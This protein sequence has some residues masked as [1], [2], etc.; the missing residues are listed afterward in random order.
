MTSS[1]GR[2]PLWYSS[3]YWR[4]AISFVVFVAV[5]LVGQSVMVSYLA[6]STDAFGP[7]NPNA[8]ATAIATEAGAELARD[9][10][11]RP[12]GVPEAALRRRAAGG[13]HRDEGRP[14][15]G[16]LGP[17]TEPRHPP[18]GGRAAAGRATGGRPARA[19]H[20]PG[21]QRADPDR[22]E[23]QGLV[24]LPPP[25]P[26]GVLSDA[27]RLLSLPGTLVLLAA[28]AIAAIVIFAPA[29]RRLRALE[30]G[31]RALRRR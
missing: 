24:V 21:G 4:I 18:A 7:G 28:T 15:G 17:R 10:P 27:G 8:A 1:A 3:F 19:R 2:R 12:H 16:Q 6:R 14:H 30:D 22:G 13:V 26:R 11:A 29:R 23:L 20:R 9:R 5:V 31:R 25:P